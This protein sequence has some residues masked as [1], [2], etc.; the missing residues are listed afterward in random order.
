MV[1]ESYC[2][3]TIQKKYSH[4]LTGLKNSLSS[5]RPASTYGSHV[6]G[7]IADIMM[8][9]AHILL[10]AEDPDFALLIRLGFQESGILNTVHVVNDGRQ[11]LSY[12]NGE[13]PYANRIGFPVPALLLVDARLQH[14]SGFEVIQW[15]REQPALGNVKVVLFSNLDTETDAHLAEELGADFYLVKPFDFQELIEIVQQI[16]ASWLQGEIFP[17]MSPV[18]AAGLSFWSP[19]QDID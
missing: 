2:S 4:A 18:P 11:A 10:A 9:V 7:E 12:L 1:C 3:S 8:D 17:H 16:G 19:K 5:W 15:I 14:I 6:F 13:G